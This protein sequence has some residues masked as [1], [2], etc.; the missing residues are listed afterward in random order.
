MVPP[1]PRPTPPE[2]EPIA[3]RPLPSPWTP[4]EMERLIEDAIRFIAEAK[5]RAGRRLGWE[6]GEWLFLNLYRGDEA[7][8]RLR[9]PGKTDSLEDLARMSGI[10]YGTLKGWVTAAAIR[11]SLESRGP[12]PDLSLKHF[13]HLGPLRDD[14]PAMRAV[15]AWAERED[16]RARDFQKA[17]SAWARR[18]EEGGRVEDLIEDPPGPKRKRGKRR[19]KTRTDDLVA[20]RLLGLATRWAR[21]GRMSGPNRE[22]LAK[23]AAG[24]RRTL[25]GRS[26]VAPRSAREAPDAQ[27]AEAERKPLPA[28]WREGGGD[29]VVERAVRFVQAAVRRTSIDFGVE[30]GGHLFRTIFRGDRDL[31]AHAGPW[32]QETIARIA[33]DPRVGL[34]DDVLY[35]C[36]HTFLLSEAWGRAAAGLPVPAISP[37]KWERLWPLEDDPESLV[38][39]A[40]WVERDDVP[41]DLVRAVALLARPYVAAGGRLEDLLA[42][43]GGEGGG[44]APREPGTPTPFARIRRILGVVARRIARVPVPAQALGRTVGE[45][46]SLIAALGAA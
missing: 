45:C 9:H 23:E 12:L 30:V 14:V 42:P 34:D 46:D 11:R 39:V 3:P 40:T 35:Q 16:V 28:P 32:K 6:V 7:Y 15:C 8:L 44:L 21:A 27:G 41:H 5:R 13:E 10:P 29:A 25:A 31:Y 26:G 43:A 24:I 17:V 22:T 38:A 19:P 37:W 36:I 4:A 1:R 33:R 20:A 18:I 2:P